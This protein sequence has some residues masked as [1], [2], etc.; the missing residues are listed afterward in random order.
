MHPS[1]PSADFATPELFGLVQAMAG[2]GVWQWE[3][4]TNVVT[5]SDELYRIYGLSPGEFG[6]SFQGY[7]ERVHPDDRDRIRTTVENALTEGHRFAF[8]ERVVRPDGRVRV[9]ESVGTVLRDEQGNPVRMIGAC[10][11][12]T[13]RRA[14]RQ[15]VAQQER[16][17]AIGTLAAGVAHEI[18]NPLLYVRAGLEHLQRVLSNHDDPELPGVLG[19]MLEGVH[20]MAKVV[21]DLRAHHTPAA[22]RE[23]VPMPLAAAVQQT[24]DLVDHDLRHRARLEVHLDPTVEVHASP[25]Q[26][27]QIVLNLLT[28]ALQA[29]EAG[30]ADENLVRVT[31]QRD[32]DEAVLTITDTGTGIPAAHASRL[33][34]PFFTTKPVGHGTGLGLFVTHRDVRALGGTIHL[35]PAS[36]GTR[37]MVRLP[38]A[39]PSHHTSEPGEDAPPRGGVLLID[40]DALVCRAIVRMLEGE[41][42]HVA[43][44]AREGLSF[45]AAGA[46]PDVILCDLM[47]PDGHGPDVY[48]TIARRW[49]NLEGRVRFITGGVF[50]PEIEAFAQ[51]H[52][53]RILHKPFSREHLLQTIAEARGTEE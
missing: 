11:D 27:H 5:W 15:R 35:E 21:K 51:R 1:G 4:A 20:H 52:A 45:L 40:D 2:L 30:H 16:L 25:D 36:R 44:S 33:F 9:L 50:A 43:S 8:D 19:D 18:N 47:M 23:A 28:N 17:S 49:P 12:V 29:I 41:T 31:V 6:A 22:A 39:R 34:D 3:V 13:E 48:R 42:V 38:V 14:L 53:T 10:M 26:L 37:A 32:G 46:L 7:L 24:V